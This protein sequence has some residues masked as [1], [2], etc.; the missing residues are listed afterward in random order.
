MAVW[1]ARAV[2]MLPVADQ[3]PGTGGAGVGVGVAVGVDFT[4]PQ[5]VAWWQVRVRFALTELGFDG[6]MLDFGEDAP[7]AARYASGQAGALLHNQYP[8]LYHR[9]AY[10]VAQATKPGAAVFFARAGYSGSQSYTTGR[11]TG[12]Q[13]RSWNRTRGLPAALTAMLSGG[14]SGWPYWGPDIAGFLDEYAVGADE[15]STV[16]ALRLAAEK[17]LW[18]RW[19]QLGALSPTMRDM[20]GMQRD[21]VG[22]WTDAETQAVFRAYARLHRALQSYLYRYAE[23]AHQHGLPILRPL[24]VNYPGETVTYTLEDEYLI[25]YDLLVAPILQPGQT[26]R[27][28][29]LPDDPWRDYWTGQGYRGPGW[30]SVPAPL[31]QVLLFIRDGAV[32]DLPAPHMLGLPAHVSATTCHTPRIAAASPTIRSPADMDLRGTDIQHHDIWR[33]AEALFQTGAAP[34]S[35]QIAPNTYTHER[36]HQPGREVH[37]RAPRHR[38]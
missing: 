25:G 18:M 20:L 8:L 27:Q 5:A 33:R 38:V 4:N 14:L 36:A 24:F 9:A 6:A 19:V 35:S 16:K 10:D 30:V 34:A 22:L 17:E 28:L 37:R 26:R 1:T 32:I 2:L 29:Y 31:H 7:V 15:P 11:F 12:D 23:Q 21:P 13:V 3:P